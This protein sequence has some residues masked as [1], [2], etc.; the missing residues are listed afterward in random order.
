MVRNRLKKKYMK[1]IS[2][3]NKR[4]YTKKRNY[5]VKLLR[6]EKINF[7]AN[8]DTKNI[9]DNKSFGQTVKPFFSDKT[10]DSDQFF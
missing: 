5:C 2:E 6:K 4:N 8:L 3:E 9:T 7:F 10:L 1:N